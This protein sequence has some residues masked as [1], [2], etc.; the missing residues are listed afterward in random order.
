MQIFTRFKQLLGV[1]IL[2]I[3]SGYSHLAMADT[4]HISA[5]FD[6][7]NL[8][9]QMYGHFQ[10]G[11]HAAFFI[12][13]DNNPKTGYRRKGKGARNIKG[14]DYLVQSNGLYKYPKG[15]KG[16][17]WEKVTSAILMTKSLTKVSARIPLKFVDLGN[18]TIRFKAQIASKNWRRYVYSQEKKFR[19]GSHIKSVVVSNNETDLILKMKGRFLKGGHPGFYLD[20]DNNP[21]T[22][23]VSKGK[24]RN[25]RG[26]DFL[27]EANGL[28]QYPKGAHGWKWKK[29]SSDVLMDKGLK[30][31]RVRIPLKLLNASN[32]IRVK[33]EMASRNWR[34]HV[35]SKNLVYQLD[36]SSGDEGP[37][38]PPRLGSVSTYA[39]LDSIG[40]EW[41][42]EGDTNEEAKCGLRYRPVGTRAWQEAWHPY[43]ISYTPPRPVAGK[44]TRFN[45]CAGSV[46]F[47]NP[48]AVYELW[49]TV[50]GGGLDDE[51]KVTVSTLSEPRIPDIASTYYVVPGI[52][53]GRGTAS[54]PYQG[55]AEAQRHAKPGDVF[56]LK[57]GSYA[58]FNNGEIRFEKA[59]EEGRWVVWKAAEDNVI[60]T[61]PV[62]IA[63]DYVW[64]E[65]VH[66]H[67]DPNHFGDSGLRTTH[68]NPRRVVIRR[69]TFKDFFYS[70]NLYQGATSWLIENN[71][72][73][74]NRDLY[75]CWDPDTGTEINSQNPD[76]PEESWRGEG[77][78]LGH[79]PGHTVRYNR[80]SHVADGISYPLENV[81]IYGN[82]IFDVTDDGIEA[83]DGYA[84]VRVWRN[85]ITNARHNGLS[86]Q[87][88]NGGP[89]YFLRNQVSAPLES[90][91]KLRHLSR[92]LLAHN[93]LIGWNRAAIA[94]YET[95]GFNRF[96]SLN[97]IYVSVSG[98]YLWDQADG[99]GSMQH[100]LDYDG[101]DA[102][103]AAYA[104]RW[105]GASYNLADFSAATGLEPHGRTIDRNRCWKDF[106]TR[107]TRPADPAPQ[108]LVSLTLEKG[109]SAIDAGIVLPNLTGAYTGDAPDLG[110]YEWK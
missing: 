95:E 7:V 70:I 59:G 58:A 72:I 15:A 109:C 73:T 51:G 77:I 61:A 4:P 14:V 80:I 27:I 2:V 90:T 64:L 98:H 37:N 69:N 11:S 29:V 44:N 63:A 57:A 39:T 83:D 41:Q 88:M 79:T 48:G 107:V 85:R 24:K 86:F 35:Y 31:V 17:K 26:A 108:P 23:Y 99:G 20:V 78:E 102:G 16:W 22:G 91:L 67:G 55:I 21:L 19:I 65:G 6:G 8:K 84:N 25:I 1:F 47:L 40:F 104:F 54:D 43:R 82:D 66:I 18:N 81:D 30:E 94:T 110:P 97:N 50:S 92:V 34:R 38:N 62:R 12:D 3:S 101:F 105:G 106:D 71:V 33:A 49:L 36:I 103:D 89:W 93:L 75:T 45:G 13:A 74:G 52:G 56:L 5:S 100:Q 76:C 68:D 10:K 87:P 9:L 28:Y 46:F 96:D 42:F 53:G 60:F 32:T